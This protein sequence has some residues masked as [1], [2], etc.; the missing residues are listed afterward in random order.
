M[1]HKNQLNSSHKSTPDV[2]LSK[3]IKLG[4]PVA[5]Q[6]AL[7]AILSLADVLMVSDFG[8]E[9]TASVGI[10][11]KW[12]FIATMIIAGM[13]SANGILVAQYWGKN[14]RRSAKNDHHTS[15]ALRN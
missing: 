1:T 6:S 3:V 5:I 2:I 10:A 4:F 9:A 8:Q 13:A 15:N 14:D 11:S 12:H 7:V